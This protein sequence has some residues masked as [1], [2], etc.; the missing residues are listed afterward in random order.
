ME[1]GCVPVQRVLEQDPTSAGNE[2]GVLLIDVGGGIGHD[3]E[4]F[5]KYHSKLPGRLILQELPSVI[6]AATTRLPKGIESMEYDFFTPQPIK[7]IDD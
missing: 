3:M 1:P 4:L 6:E 2:D 5:Q 7:G